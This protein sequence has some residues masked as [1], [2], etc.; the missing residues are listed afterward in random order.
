MAP[1]NPD[2]RLDQRG[3]TDLDYLF[4]GAFLNAAIKGVA[5]AQMEAG[6]GRHVI[7]TDIEHHAVLHSAQYLERF[8]FE[9]DLLPVFAAQGLV[10]RLQPQRIDE[11]DPATGAERLRRD[12][13]E[14]GVETIDIL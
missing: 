8:G 2:S 1:K 11:D 12:A 3:A 13:E 6:V 5:F 10:V 14:V 9:V 7:T 4:N